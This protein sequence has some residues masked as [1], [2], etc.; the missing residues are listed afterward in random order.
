MPM[1]IHVNYARKK[2]DGSFGI[3]IAVI[4]ILIFAINMLINT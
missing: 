4:Y 3:K 1:F 2:Q